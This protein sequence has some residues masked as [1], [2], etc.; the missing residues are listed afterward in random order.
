[1]GSSTGQG[2]S[3][4]LHEEEKLSAGATVSSLGL[5]AGRG[6]STDFQ[7]HLSVGS[8]DSFPAVLSSLM[9]RAGRANSW[10]QTEMRL[11]TWEG[12]IDKGSS[13]FGKKVVEVMGCG[14]KSQLD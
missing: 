10:I 14:L 8:C 5:E 1:M 3:L 13:A 7:L 11:R 6:E 9:K 12:Q 2:L 4:Q